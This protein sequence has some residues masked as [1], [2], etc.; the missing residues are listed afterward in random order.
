MRQIKRLIPALVAIVA[1]SV[2]L[3]TFLQPS[4]ALMFL[5][6]RSPNVIY[7]VDTEEAVIALTIDDGPDPNTT[8]EI[9]K[10]L[11]ENNAKATFFLLSDNVVGNEGLVTSILEDGH[12]IGNHLTSQRPSILYSK[13][14]FESQLLQAHEA[15][16]QFSSLRWFRPGSGWYNNA[17]L[18][19]LEKHDYQCVLGSVYPFDAAV[20]SSQFASMYVMW[21]VKPGAIIVLHDSDGRGERTVETLGTILPELVEQGF[22]ITTL[23]ELVGYSE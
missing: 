18:S 8:L 14:D 23:S 11:K 15:L 7:S 12:E 19:T 1:L 17:M 6:K 5:E 21:R 3:I 16:S 22:R 2:S 10:V 4:W 13:S 20:P 9:L